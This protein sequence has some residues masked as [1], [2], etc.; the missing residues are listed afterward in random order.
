VK[1]SIQVSFKTPAG[2]QVD[3][4][5]TTT[6]ATAAAWERKFKR[7]ASDL[8]GGIGIDDLMFMAWH[9][10]HAQKREGRDYDTWLQSVEDFSVVEV[11]QANPTAAAV[12]DDS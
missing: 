6:I 11:A 9:A 8:Q 3:E 1:L 4:L 12:S 7:R 10:L 5:V 2:Q